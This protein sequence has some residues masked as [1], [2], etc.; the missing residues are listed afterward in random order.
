[1]AGN[2]ARELFGVLAARMPSFWAALRGPA[3]AEV[4]APAPMPALAEAPAVPALA[5]GE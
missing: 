1:V 3:T 5:P 4:A 2:A